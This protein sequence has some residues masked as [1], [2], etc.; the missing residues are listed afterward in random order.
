MSEDKNVSPEKNGTKELTREEARQKREYYLALAAENARREDPTS[1][2]IDS[3]DTTMATLILP[4][5]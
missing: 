5:G 4:G 2:D 3:A 1:N